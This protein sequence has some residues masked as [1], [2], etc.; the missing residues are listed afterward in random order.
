MDQGLLEAY[1][2]TDYRVFGAPGFT[3]RVGTRSGDL[4]RI[5][6]GHGIA[7]AAFITAFN[8]FSMELSQEEN[9]RRQDE[10]RDVVFTLGLRFMEGI[11]QHP[12]NGWPGEESLLILGGPLKKMRALGAQFG[13]NA[14]VWVGADAVPELVLLQTTAS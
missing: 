3:L 2:Q 6:A 10:L 14:I 12:S 11:G 1:V 8:P 5:C 9:A 13:Q 4:A 7:T